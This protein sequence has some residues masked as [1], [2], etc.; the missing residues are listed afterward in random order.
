MAILISFAMVMSSSADWAWTGAELATASAPSRRGAVADA[1]SETMREVSPDDGGGWW[2]AAGSAA[3]NARRAL[4]R[5]VGE[6]DH[7]ATASAVPG[8]APAWN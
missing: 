7:S 4:T 8:R 3:R 2:F 6:L 5:R 1:G